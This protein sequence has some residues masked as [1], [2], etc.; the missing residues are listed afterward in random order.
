[1]NCDV[2]IEIEDEKDV[3]YFGDEITFRATVTGCEGVNYQINWEYN[4]NDMED[5]V[6]WEYADSGETFTF[7]ITEENADW[8]WRAAIVIAE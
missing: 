2:E 8:Q 3:Y 4:D 6:E 5:E 1:M 7:V